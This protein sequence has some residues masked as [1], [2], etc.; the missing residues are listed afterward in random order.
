MRYGV[1][2][3]L[4][5]LSAAPRAFAAPVPPAGEPVV[6]DAALTDG[7]PLFGNLSTADD[8]DW[9]YFEAVQGQ[10]IRVTVRRMSGNLKPNTGLY[11]GAFVTSQPVGAASPLAH[12]N[13]SSAL[14]DGVVLIYTPSFS[15]PVTLYVSTWSIETGDYKV[16]VTGAGSGA[17]QTGN[18]D[19]LPRQP[20]DP[21]EDPSAHP[22]TPQGP[23][24]QSQSLPVGLYN[25]EATLRVTDLRVPGRGFDFVWER[26]YTSRSDFSGHLGHN[27]HLSFNR[28]VQ[29]SNGAATIVDGRGR[30]DAYAQGSGGNFISPLG[31]FDALR[32]NANGTFSQR[33]PDGTIRQYRT[34]GWLVSITDRHG[35]T[36]TVNRNGAGEITT[37]VDTQGRLYTFAYAGGRIQS[38]TDFA[39]RQVVY[40]YDGNG[41]LVKVRSPV[42]TGMPQPENDFPNGKTFLYTYS[43]GTGNP[44]RDHNLLSVIDPLYNVNDDPL[45]SKAW[46]TLAYYPT[47][48]PASPEFDRV[49]A[50]RWGN[51]Q[52]GPPGNPGVV[53]GGTTTYAY[54]EGLAGDPDAPST[55]FSRTIETDRNGNVT[56]HY[57]D[58]TRHE[59]KTIE[60]MN[61]DVRPG[62]GPHVTTYAYTPEGLLAEKTLPRGNSVAYLYTDT[63]GAW[64]FSD[65]L[66]LEERRKDNALG[67][68]PDLVTRYTYEPVFQQ[69]RSMTDPREFPSGVVPPGFDPANSRYTTLSFFDYQEG[70]G[71][72][73]AQGVPASLRIPEGLGNL[74][75]AAD[76]NEGNIVRVRHPVIQTPGPNLGQTAETVKTWNDRGQTLTERDPEG[77]VV[78]H[79][80]FPTNGNPNDP[81]DREG[82]LRFRRVDQTG[83]NLTTEYGYDVQGNVTR[84]VDPRGADTLYTV[85]PLN[86]VVRTLSREVNGGGGFRYQADTIWDANNEVKERRIQNLDENG[87][88]YPN[89]ELTET[90]EYN[91]LHFAVSQT[92]EKT[93]N[94]G[95][96]A[97]TVRTEYFYDANLNRT[98][99]KTPLSVSGA[100]GDNIVTTRYDERDLVYKVI[101]GDTDTDPATIPA[102]AAVATTN[103]DANKNLLERID[104]LRDN[105]NG[106]LSQFLGSAPGD[107]TRM[108]YDGFDRLTSVTDGEVNI[109][110]FAYDMADNRRQETITGP[111][112]E[113]GAPVRLLAQTDRLFDER[114]RLV[115]STAQ[116]FERR[117]GNPV[118]D[119]SGVT[120]YTYDRDSKTTR[121]TD[122]RGLNT[123]TQWDAA[124]RVFKVIDHLTNEVEYAYDANSNVTTETR[125]DISTDL[126]TPVETYVT[127]NE[128]DGLDRLKKTTDPAGSVREFLYDSRDNLVKTS[129]GV[130][131][132]NH[133]GGPGNTVLMDYDGLDRLVKTDRIITANGRGDTGEVD[134]I[135]TL[136]GWDDNSRLVTQTDDNNHAT[137]YGYDAKDRRTSETLA[138]G[139]AKSWQYNEDDNNTQWT[140]AN[141]TVCLHAFDGLNRLKTKTVTRGPGVLGATY[142]TIGYDGA[143]Q[144]TKIESDDIL[145]GVLT[146][147]FEYDSLGNTTKDQ[148][149]GTVDSVYDGVGNRVQCTYPGG[150]GGPRRVLTTAYDNLNRMQ[151]V[152]DAAPIANFHYKGPVRCERRTYGP[153]ATPI[154]FVDC[155]YDAYPREIVKHHQTGAGGLI[156]RFEYGY[157]K[158]HHRLFEKRI[159]DGNLGDVY[160]YDS[161][162]RV[163]RNPQNVDLSGVPAG[164][165]ILSETFASPDELAYAYDGV[166]NRNTHTKTT[167]GTPV[168]TAYT[169]QAGP[170]P[171]DAEVNQYTQIQ[172]GGNPAV[173]YLYDENGNLKS[174]GSKDFFYD[175]KNRLVE[176]R[177]TAGGALV[178]QYSHDVANRRIIKTEP[179]L[180]T[181]FAYD[182]IQCVEERDGANAITRQY[183]WGPGTD[184]LLQQQIPTATYYSHENS[185]GSVCA[186]TDATGAVVERY[187]YDPFGNTTVTLNGNTGNRYRFHAMYDDPETDLRHT[188]N[189]AYNPRLGRWMQRDPIGGW[190]DEI[191]SGNALAFAG[192]NGVN[193]RD[194]T[195]MM[196]KTQCK[197]L[198]AEIEESQ[199]VGEKLK[200]MFTKWKP[201]ETWKD[202]GLEPEANVGGYRAP[203][204]SAR[205]PAYQSVV[206]DLEGD[207]GLGIG[208]G[209]M[210]AIIGGAGYYTF[211]LHGLIHNTTAAEQWWLTHITIEKARR[212]AVTAR[213]QAIYDK[214][215]TEKECKEKKKK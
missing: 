33:A 113:T 200:D 9:F 88:A 104:E 116:H 63:A 148:N 31:F 191:N 92:R 111:V 160:Q 17:P 129:D 90:H 171:H 118:G 212:D 137:T 143:S 83:F 49:Q 214:E 50:Q 52:G 213:L 120:T 36:Q 105:P 119:G 41:D 192:N 32:Q 154:S 205:S 204:F 27:W 2:L 128:Y 39:G 6:Y 74:N 87:A 203:N 80:Y 209:A 15:G 61:R 26:T 140:D 168:V 187:Q 100:Q 126:G 102:G 149:A 16:V 109:R 173:G 86:Q 8:Y 99:V 60:E 18:G 117:T 45:Q 151:S 145:G 114:N 123:D 64:R 43:S 62:E 110:D 125:R 97:G 48:D 96:A 66:L 210:Q 12:T 98:A 182:G 73:A 53:V 180:T 20:A 30:E 124:D 91:I 163:V 167:A 184:E 196:S 197:Q 82:Y 157:D 206:N 131:G 169:L 103:Y 29:A 81:S 201:G 193:F 54:S 57:F 159:H 138:D 25:G 172:E 150:F 155:L 76:F 176:V 165:E 69:Q 71:F 89:G 141:G 34:D 136:Q 208:F 146:C 47:N 59:I 164:T 121:V 23:S 21:C 178:A 122:D 42:V 7:A 5:L 174:D 166:Q 79:E 11:A 134:R 75:G 202:Y 144:A 37:I 153:D 199:R 70:A 127:L 211:G 19:Q 179:A 78:A 40:T 115:T 188:D 24:M 67:T 14:V 194:P 161:V 93:K 190:E 10:E 139:T 46:V 112:D 185:I 142:E 44:L 133:P 215:C 84:M 175:F 186:L 207:V 85:N 77:T 3:F 156:A 58:G 68:A 55:A 195:G 22:N 108:D 106:L 183:V 38:I 177:Q 51:D 135:T 147:R 132:G 130:R 181:V 1:V 72:Q 189:R 35:N 95:T 4:F 158:E 94:D 13:N 152:S 56:K 101:R 198:K 170:P 28:R 107:V 162:Y 65:G